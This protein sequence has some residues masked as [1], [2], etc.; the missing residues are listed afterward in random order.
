MD[1]FEKIII[2]GAVIF[3]AVAAWYNTHHDGYSVYCYRISGTKF[4]NCYRVMDK[5]GG[6]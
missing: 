2:I 1:T 6:E 4:S 5:K 3:A